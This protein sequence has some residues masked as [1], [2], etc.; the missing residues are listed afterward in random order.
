MEMVRGKAAVTR[1]DPLAA[2]SEVEA[3]QLAGPLARVVE[4]PSCPAARV[5][6]K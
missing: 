2:T 5:A 3:V 1:V 6:L 4:K